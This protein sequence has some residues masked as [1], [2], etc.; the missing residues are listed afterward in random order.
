MPRATGNPLPTFMP[1]SMPLDRTPTRSLPPLS[2]PFSFP[3]ELIERRVRKN[4]FFAFPS[5]LLHRLFNLGH[6]PPDSGALWNYL[7][8]IRDFETT[9][10]PLSHLTRAL[11][12]R[13]N[14]PVF[15]QV[16][17]Q[18]SP[19]SPSLSIRT[20]ATLPPLLVF[21]FVVET[22]H[23]FLPLRKVPDS[24][25]PPKLYGTSEPRPCR[26]SSP[27]LSRP[28]ETHPLENRRSA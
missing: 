28:S 17:T 5:L 21:F 3:F 24:S 12:R 23:F 16:L 8:V 9:F 10:P 18:T 7:L 19:P 13:V 2:S 26:S 20:V 27:S 22:H 4:S 15:R 1:A 6:L 25:P 14:F 11:T